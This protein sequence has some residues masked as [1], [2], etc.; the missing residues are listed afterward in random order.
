MHTHIMGM[1]KG[2]SNLVRGFR[3]HVGVDVAGVSDG[4]HE[5]RRAGE[6]VGSVASS[7]GRR[8]QMLAGM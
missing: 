6:R 2:T 4:R 3:A 1:C 5:S 7:E 8:G